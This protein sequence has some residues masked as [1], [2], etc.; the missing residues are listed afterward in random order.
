MKH[1]KLALACL[2][3]LCSPVAA[4]DFDK[5]LAAYRAKD[6]SS[7]LKEWQPLAKQGNAA[8]QHNLGLIYKLGLGVPKNNKESAKWYTLAAEQGDAKAQRSIG[9]MHE[10][11]LGILQNHKKA[12]EWYLL[13]AEQGNADA[14]ISLGNLYFS[15]EGVPQDYKTAAKWVTLAAE[16]GNAHAQMMLAMWYSTW[17]IRPTDTSQAKIYGHMWANIS[18]TNGNEIAKSHRK[19]YAKLMDLAE[20]EKAQAMARK[21]MESDYK[22]CGY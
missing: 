6:Y 12:A 10:F 18:A 4:Q 16:Q 2:M 5:G 14:Q 21:C 20:L 9:K 8:A 13:A 7:A 1:I 19:M 17:K 3:M 15:G 22:E 11:G